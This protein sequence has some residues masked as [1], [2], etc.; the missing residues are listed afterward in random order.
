MSSDIENVEEIDSKF[1]HTVD[2]N[3][4]GGQSS[5]RGDSTALKKKFKED[6]SSR[7][8]LE[9]KL[10]DSRIYRQVREFDFDDLD[11]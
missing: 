9:Q 5:N 3:S 11:E 6:F 10:E 8:R 7:R 1:Q 2:S 4:Q